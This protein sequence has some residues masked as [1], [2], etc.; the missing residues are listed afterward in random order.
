MKR[1]VFAVILLS[2]TAFAQ[3]GRPAPP[4]P[5]IGKLKATACPS[6]TPG[7]PHVCLSWTASTSTGVAGYNVYR[8]T[9]SGGESYATPLNATVDT[10]TS[11]YDATTAIGSTY[12]YTV[13]AVGTGGVLSV[14]SGEVSAQ[15][16]VPPNPPSAPSA[17]ID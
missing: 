3:G 2:A 6:P 1:L 8:S 16:P 10:G 5:S 15:I 9:T 13:T 14:P 11:Y 12:F 4:K 17:S 7:A